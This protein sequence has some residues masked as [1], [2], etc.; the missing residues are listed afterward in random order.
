MS[1]RLAMGLALLL[2]GVLVLLWT[3]RCGSAGIDD[4]PRDSHELQSERAALPARV[5]FPAAIGDGAA[6]EALASAAAGVLRVIVVDREGRAAPGKLAVR[7][8][9]MLPAFRAAVDPQLAALDPTIVVHEHRGTVELPRV[10]EQWLELCASGAAGMARALLEPARAAGELRLVLDA[11]ERRIE[12]LVV[13]ADLVTPLRGGAVLVN[14]GEPVPIDAQGRAHIELGERTELVLQAPGADPGDGSPFVERVVAVPA[15]LPF[16]RALTLVQPRPRA[17]LDLKIEV[18]DQRGGDVLALR[19][20]DD[21]SFAETGSRAPLRPGAQKMRFRLDE[22]EYQPVTWPLGRLI[23]DGGPPTIH[24][25]GP[26]CEAAIAL[27]PQTERVTL[28]LSGIE[29]WKLPVH[30]LPQPADGLL[31]VGEC[32]AFVGPWTWRSLSAELEPLAG[33]QRLVAHGAEGTW[34]S[35]QPWD[36]RSA[37]LRMC[38][39]SRVDLHWPVDRRGIT[40]AW[41]EIH[42]RFGDEVVPLRLGIRRTVTGSVA[43]FV[44]SCFV[45]AGSF[46]VSGGFEG[47]LGIGSLSRSAHEVR[48]ARCAVEVDSSP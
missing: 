20:V 28:R 10:L 13:A 2:P 47:E 26:H 40:R 41:A 3:L 45:P 22:G 35:E 19:R 14:G 42:S 23:E 43:G 17:D 4:V 16:H 27:S 5:G 44:G 38:P 7:T 25:R 37:E 6:R 34:I 30:V 8:S 11:T 46:W 18:K 29:P 39:A 21:G 15:P 12:V 33:P 9:R 32:G 36:G 48:A 31:V 1:S 24:V